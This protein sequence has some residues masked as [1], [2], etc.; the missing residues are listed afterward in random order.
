MKAGA[1]GAPAEPVWLDGCGYAAWTG[2]GRFVR[3]CAGERRRPRRR[4]R[5][6]RADV[7]AE[8]PREPGRRRAQRH[9]R[10][11]HLDGRRGPAAG[12]QL[13]RDHSSRGRD[14]GRRADHRGDDRDGPARALR[15]QHA[16]RRQRRRPRRPAGPHHD[17]PA[18]RQRQRSR[19]RRADDARARRRS[20][21]RRRCSRSTTAVRCRSRCPR[22]RR[23]RRRSAT[24][25]PTAAAAPTPRRCRSRCTAGTSTRHRRRSASRRWRSRPAATITYNVLPDWI[26]PDGDD[27]F[28]S[29]VV[30]AEGD[31]ADFTSDGR[32]T[33]RAVGGTQ[34]R[35]DVE[36]T[37]SDG[38][39]VTVGAV[40]FDVRPVGSIDPVT[41]ADYI[42]VRTGQTA[43]VVAAR[44]RRRRGPRAAA[45]GACRP[46][47]RRRRSSPTTPTRP[48][49]SAPRR[50]A[51][52]TCSTWWPPVPPASPGI[53]R[54]DVI[55]E[56]E[57]D[58]PPVAVRDVALLPSGGEVLVN[59]L[60]NDS[61]PS[62]GILVVQSVTVEPNSGIAVAGAQPRDAAHQRPGR[63]LGAGAHLVPHLERLAVGRGRCHRHPHSGARAAAAAGRQRRPGGRAR[64][65]RRDD[66]GAR[67]R[68]PP[69]R[70]HH[71][72]RPRPRAAAHRSR[73][74]R[75][76]RLAGH[77]ALPGR[78]T[79]PA[80]S[81]R[82][83]RPSTARDRRMPA[84]SRSR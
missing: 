43:T 54:V 1:E 73:G 9:R 78:P 11:G 19:R 44:E 53:V 75:G 80:P 7:A 36:I 41:N 59:V 45:P 76:L 37:V 28:L 18:A 31:E 40:R 23:V 60:T 29:S 34:G 38:S 21:G 33:Y 49:P 71:P 3:D 10:R 48:S 51:P 58:L 6:H 83:T 64:R 62:G 72:R 26:D 12:R 79:S 4:H 77:R 57:T 68:L 5:R 47:E 70:R 56:G 22:T 24:R 74:R 14:R 82:P 8:V 20:V 81:T 16:A 50:P 27:V 15:D 66:P 65:R 25:S 30:P 13:G 69:Q 55:P 46:G 61:D 42:A 63:A 2:S 67:Q 17:P 84:T 39:D 35:K 32:I 52:T